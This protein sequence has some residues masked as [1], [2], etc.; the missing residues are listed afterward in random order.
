[1]VE[2]ASKVL[3]NVSCDGRKSDWGGVY[4]SHV[5]D[6]LACLRIAFG[7]NCI[8][9]GIEKRS[10]FEV[11]ISDML[12]GPFDFSVDKRKP[13]IGGHSHIFP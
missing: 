12:F 6:Q 10:S 2:S 7:G 11:E 8:W 1:M 13:L 4:S 3:K 5:I 9:I